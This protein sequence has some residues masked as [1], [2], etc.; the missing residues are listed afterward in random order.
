MT[1]EGHQRPGIVSMA[2]PGLMTAQSFFNS[3]SSKPD[4]VQGNL[5]IMV[6]RSQINSAK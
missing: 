5:K 1:D 6:K 4:L 2:Q 3:A